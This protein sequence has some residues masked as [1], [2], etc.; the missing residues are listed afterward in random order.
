MT[1]FRIRGSG[2][3]PPRHHPERSNLGGHAEQQPRR[4]IILV[5]AFRTNERQQRCGV[6]QRAS[7]VEGL[8]GGGVGVDCRSERG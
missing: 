1:R 7:W 4:R 5:G 8:S 2:R 3:N 6:H